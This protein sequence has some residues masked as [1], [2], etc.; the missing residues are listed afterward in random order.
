M[1]TIVMYIYMYVRN[2]NLQASIIAKSNVF[3]AQVCNSNTCS[4]NVHVSTHSYSVY[5]STCGWCA[6]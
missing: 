6:S 2:G 1:H 4:S 5:V 3:I